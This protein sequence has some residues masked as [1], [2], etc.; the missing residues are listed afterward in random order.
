MPL[1]LFHAAATGDRTAVMHLLANGANAKAK[2]ADGKFPFEVAMAAEHDALTA[3]LLEVSVGINGTDQKGWTPLNWAVLSGDWQLVKELLSEGA[4][5]FAGH[6]QN[7]LDVAMLMDNEAELIQAFITANNIDIAV[8]AEQ[9]ANVL[10]LLTH[11]V[12][13][14]HNGEIVAD[15]AVTKEDH[16]LTAIM[17]KAGVGINGR[18]EKGW[19]PLNWAVLSGDWPLVQELLNEG[20]DI[21]AGYPEGA[22]SV[23]QRM[24]SEIQLA[25]SVSVATGEKVVDENYRRI[26]LLAARQ[27]YTDIVSMLLERGNVDLNTKNYEGGYTPLMLAVRE[28]HTD[29]VSMLLARDDVDLNIKN[30]NGCTALMLAVQGEHDDIVKMLLARDDVDLNTKANRGQGG[31]TALMLAAEK[32]HT[33][34]VSMLLARADVDL[35]AKDKGYY[36]YTALMLAAREGNTDVVKMLLERDDV[37]LNAKTKGY[38]GEHTPLML[39]A[40]KGHTDVVRVLLARA[41]VDLN[42]KNNDGYT[43]LMLAVREGYAKLVKMLVERGAYLDTTDQQGYEAWQ[44]A[45]LEGRPEIVEILKD[46]QR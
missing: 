41:D 46:A 33:D 42:I 5:I 22:L 34:I 12:T 26:T 13:V 38:K 9:A 4:K 25:E 30:S 31:G 27:G 44:L 39:A 43:A 20:A 6:Y 32:G 1:N 3:I 18:D 17:L 15:I 21:F 7:A 8:S 24:Q 23:A 2:N 29:I 16:A 10:H 35:N 19:P 37:D 11:G 36:G 14:D 45:D 28:G 40:E